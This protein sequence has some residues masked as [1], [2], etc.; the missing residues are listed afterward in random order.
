MATDLP[1]D[2]EEILLVM[3]HMN[4]VRQLTEWAMAGI[5]LRKS[6]SHG[7]VSGFF[8]SSFAVEAFD[9]VVD[10]PGAEKCTCTEPKEL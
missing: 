3:K 7:R 2:T 9:Q 5:K 6:I 4:G 10:V 8:V 1:A